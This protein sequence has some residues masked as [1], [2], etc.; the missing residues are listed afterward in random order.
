MSRTLGIPPGC[1][2]ISGNP[3]A[4]V[5]GIGPNH[6]ASPEE[7]VDPETVYKLNAPPTLVVKPYDQ[8]ELGF[9][10]KEKFCAAE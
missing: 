3:G 2:T 4:V 10:V 8:T 7:K 5:P 6:P 1:A 9:N